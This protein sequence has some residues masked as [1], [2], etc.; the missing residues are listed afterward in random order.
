[1]RNQATTLE[2]VARAK[3]IGPREISRRVGI[4]ESQVRNILK[5]R[6]EPKARTAIKIA[7]V[8]NSTVERLWP[9]D[10]AA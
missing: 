6:N 7:H 2:T 3:K 10:E 1:M 9:L 8:L 5:G 4:C